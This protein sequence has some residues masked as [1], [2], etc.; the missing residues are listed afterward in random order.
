VNQPFIDFEQRVVVLSGAAGGIGR[1]IA[2]QLALLNARLILLGR[3]EARLQNL[4]KE[5]AGEQHQYA[6]LDLLDI[7]NIKPAL[8]PLLQSSGGVY[9]FCHCAG[10]IYLRPLN[11]TKQD[12][13]AQQMLVNLSSGLEITKLTS[14]RTLAAKDAGSI[15]FVSSICADSGSAGQIGYCASKGAVNAAVRA[16]AIEMAPRNIRVNSVSPGAILNDMTVTKS[17]LSA[18]QIEQVLSKYPLSHGREIDVARAVVF[19]LAPEN[20]WITG[21]DFKVDG[22]FSAQ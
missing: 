7:D 1:A 9:G 15:V 2:K 6:V 14:N 10:L 18:E 8:T 4:I 13:L 12:L 16:M 17:G 11:S 21:V 3:D 5:L 22:G 20:T 19:L